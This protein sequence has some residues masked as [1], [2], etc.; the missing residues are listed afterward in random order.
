MVTGQIESCEISG[1]DR[2]YCSYSLTYGKEWELIEGIKKGLSQTSRKN[3]QS[4]YEF[5]WNYPFALTFKSYNPHGW[6]Q[7]LIAV[8][9]YNSWSQDIIVG[10]TSVRIPM[11]NNNKNIIS[12]DLYRPISSNALSEFISWMK[13]NPP[14]YY[15][16]TTIAK[17]DVREVTR[18]QSNGKIKINFNILTKN[19][20]LFGYTINDDKI[21]N[22][23]LH[24]ITRAGINSSRI[25]NDNVNA[26]GNGTTVATSGASNTGTSAMSLNA[27][28]PTKSQN[29]ENIARKENEEKEPLLS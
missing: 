28:N 25:V 20:K 15:D 6:P 12:C 8:Y 18:V 4:K 13:G 14:E 23:N 21:N 5:L 27:T 16:I 22:K 29:I 17:S 11:F 7:L 2:L 24:F 3:S 26:N 10:Y 1:Y 19:L 9:A